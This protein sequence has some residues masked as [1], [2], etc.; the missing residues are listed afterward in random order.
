[1]IR[2]LR[3]ALKMEGEEG[4]KETI[5]HRLLIA[6]ADL[7]VHGGFI[8]TI[9][10]SVVYVQIIHVKK[11]KFLAITHTHTHTQRGKEYAT[12]I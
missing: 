11:I 1:M 6:K 3:F 8:Y 2:C 7:W 10:P 12:D 4:V 9:L 5:G